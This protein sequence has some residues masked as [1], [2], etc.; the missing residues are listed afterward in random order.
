LVLCLLGTVQ[1]VAGEPLHA[2]IDREIEGKLNGQVAA[3]ATDAEFLR[4]VMLDL[5]GMIPTAAE[6]RAFLDDPSPYKR[7]R[8]IDRLLAS[9]E[10]ARRMQYVFDA[11]LMERRDDQHVPAKEWREFLR[12]SFAENKPYDKLVAEIVSA[13][14]SDPATRPA[15]K[16]YLDRGG[17]PYLITRDVGRLFLGVDM[18]CAQCHDHPLIDDYK[19]AHYYGLYAFFSRTSLCTTEPGKAPALGEK[20]D[21]DVTFVSVFKKK[22]T[23]KTGPRLFDLAPIAEPGVAKGW[24]YLVAPNKENTIRP[25]PRYSRLAQL[26][27]RLVSADVPAFRRNIANRLWAMMMGRGLVH[28]VDL[29]H[30]DN[31]PSYPALLDRLGNEL[32]AMHYD[33][34]G[35]LRELALSRTY[36]RSAEPPPGASAEWADPARFAVAAL[37]PLSA[38]Q[39]GWSVMQGLGIVSAYRSNAERAVDVVDPRLRDILRTDAKR[40]KRRATMIEES[41]FDQLSGNIAPF[42][43]QFAGSAGQSPDASG[44]TVHQALFLANGWPIQGW[45]APNDAFLVGRLTKLSDPSSVAEELYLSVYSRRP[46][47]EERAEVARYLA[48]R[49]KERTQAIQELAWA[50]L[51]STEFRFN[52]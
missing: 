37:K 18:Q 6:A 48:Q 49:G 36:Q 43:H 28:P 32:A 33:I 46:A 19:Q 50:L 41:V 44:S 31:P 21:G 29:H 9:P 7:E 45:L 22:V 24:E 3:P 16:F 51:A 2:A 13:D 12:Q 52:H 8:L 4:R 25:V 15:A 17:E 38:E 42:E 47:E 26:A 5:A 35:F 39:L 1:A 23:H 14:G 10:Y 11:M 20:A 30:S 34:K 40:Q 27:P